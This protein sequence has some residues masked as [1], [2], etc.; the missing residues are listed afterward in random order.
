MTGKTETNFKTV[1]F[2]TAEEKIK[3]LRAWKQFIKN[4]FKEKFFTKRLYNHLTLHCSF[5][6]HYDKAG[7][8]STYFT[9]PES[10]TKFIRQFDKDFDYMSTEYGMNYWIKGDFQDLN[11]AMCQVIEEVKEELYKRF[12]EK[13]KQDILSQIHLLQNKYDRL[14]R[15]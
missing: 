12:Q 5:I 6:A 2:M 14:S 15:I 3:V 13:T 10:T 4:D 8:Y 9:N 7:F 1:E 11:L